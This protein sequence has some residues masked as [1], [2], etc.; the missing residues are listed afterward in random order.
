MQILSTWRIGETSCS[1]LCSAI[2]CF[3]V[4][5]FIG[6]W[7]V[8]NPVR[9]VGELAL[10][11]FWYLPYSAAT[12]RFLNEEEKKLAFH[13]IQVDSSSEVNEKFA[14]RDALKIFKHPTSWIIL[15]M[16]SRAFTDFRNRDLSWC[17]S[18]ISAT[19][20]SCYYCSFGIQHR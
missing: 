11:A 4:W 10:F 2:H 19:I 17:P 7:S 18:S 1:V 13:R 12:A 3:G 9:T 16:T 20:S 8:S 15:G 6:V 14:L 5:G